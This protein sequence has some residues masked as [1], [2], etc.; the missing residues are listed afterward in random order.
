L[1]VPSDDAPVAPE[2]LLYRWVS[3]QFIKRTEDGLKVSG[4]AFQNTTKPIRTNEMSV[5]LQDTLE[6]LDRTPESLVDATGGFGLVALSAQQ[7]IDEEQTV[8]RTPKPDEPAH[9][10]VVG[11]KKGSRRNRFAATCQWIVQPDQD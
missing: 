3:P 2:T 9:G 4:G 11:E 8:Q 6:A 1:S 10:D 7:V 5:F